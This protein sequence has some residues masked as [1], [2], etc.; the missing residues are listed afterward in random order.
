M[1]E[2]F[3]DILDQCLFNIR[4]GK[5]TV[6]SSLARY[7]QYAERL[8][9]I[10]RVVARVQPLPLSPLNP[11]RRAQAKARLLERADQLASQ[12]KRVVTKGSISRPGWLR[13][14]PAAVVLVMICSFVGLGVTAA[15]ADSLPGDILYPI[16]R[17]SEQVTSA[18]TSAADQPEMHIQFAQRR[19]GEF[20]AL[21]ARGDFNEDLVTEASAEISEALSEVK[22]SSGPEQQATLQDIVQT[23]DANLQTLSTIAASAPVFKR[24]GLQSAA[25]ALTARRREAAELLMMKFP[26]TGVPTRPNSPGATVVATVQAGVTATLTVQTTAAATPTPESGSA[27]TATPSN[28]EPPATPPGLARTPKPKNTPPG[29][30][31]PKTTP[32]KNEAPPNNSPP[33]HSK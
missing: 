17:A 20:E 30:V 26:S 27:M 6:E 14:M 4:L 2:E 16:K 32:P 31:K 12:H 25:D 18:L 19:L 33:G 28:H 7:P 10:L 22:Q 29:Q 8:R 11:D 24:M 13:L 23:A 15:A 5:G 1:M 9:P 21:S 3:D